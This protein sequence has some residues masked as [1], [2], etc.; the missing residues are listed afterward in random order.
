MDCRS[1]LAEAEVEYQDK[2]SHSIDVKF[3]VLPAHVSSTCSAFGIDV[4]EDIAIVIWTTT[5]W[6]IPS[7]VAVCLN[8]EFDYV[9]V[10]TSQGHLILAE[11]LVEGCSNR[12]GLKMKIL[13]STSGK[14]LANIVL[15]H[16][17][18]ERESKVLLGDHVT[19]E[20]GTGC[21]HTAPAHGLDDYFICI[22]S[23]LE[24]IK[25]LDNR[26]LFKQ[27]YGP[28]AGLST[29]KGDPIVIELLQESNS[30]IANKEYEH[31]YP[32]CW[33]HKSPLIFMSTPQWFI[34]MDKSGLI[35]G[36]IN[37][38]SQVKWEPEWGEQRILSMLEDRPDWCISRQRNWGVPIPLIIHNE[39]GNIHPKQ[40]ILFN[41]IANVMEDD[42]IES[43]DNLDL[44]T[45]IDDAGLISKGT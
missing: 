16:P 28:L 10:E 25:A 4:L 20:N 27:D 29:A 23:G 24:S 45:L 15:Q 18:Y 17:L 3:T 11:D 31:S 7:N 43:W 6:T 2:I 41:E 13:G 30:L 42:G 40:N 38:V 35:D 34:S 26:G 5:P 14:N 37:A 22:K 39:T 32:H 19:T 1:A 33:R 12:W 36:A 44:D 8:Q 21:V 9:L